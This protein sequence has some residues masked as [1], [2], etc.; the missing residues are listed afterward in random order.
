MKIKQKNK[1]NYSILLIGTIL[2]CLLFAF[3]GV[4]NSWFT[5]GENKKINLIINISNIK[6]VVYQQEETEKRKIV[7][8][9]DK[10][11][12]PSY[13]NLGNIEILPDQNYNL[14]LT[15]KNEDTG[16]SSVYLK[17]KLQFYISGYETDTPLDVNIT[18]FDTPSSTK[19]GFVYNSA[20][21]Y[22][23]YRGTDGTNQKF[24]SNT[25]ATIITNFSIPY[26]SFV[27]ENLNP[28]YNGEI[29]KLVLTVEG[30]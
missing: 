7:P 27:D 24:A 13:V 17:Y 6:I 9:D 15:I 11:G 14:T 8:Y 28:V 3:M 30:F 5:Q 23:Y 4:T 22:Y 19:A 26:S 2:A 10:T 29:I 12:D 25:E 18:G 1:F 21:G 20:D 16:A